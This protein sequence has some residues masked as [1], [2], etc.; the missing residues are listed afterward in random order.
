APCPGFDGLGQRHRQPRRHSEDRGTPLDFGREETHPRNAFDERADRGSC[1]DAGELRTE[2]VMDAAAESEGRIGVALDVE[3]I[4]VVEH[5]RI[6]V[7]GAEE[8]VDGRILRNLHSS[9]EYVLVKY[10]AGRENRSVEAETFFDRPLDELGPLPELLE[11]LAVN[12][13]L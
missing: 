4:R 8:D 12:E 11:L 3:A 6:A 2:A 10:A 13:Q 5:F 9:D 7:R 1:F